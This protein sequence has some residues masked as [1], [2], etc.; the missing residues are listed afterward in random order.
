M[1]A[2]RALWR[3]IKRYLDLTKTKPRNVAAGVALGAFLAFVPEKCGLVAFVLFVVAMTGAS[4]TAAALVGVLLKTV[5]IYV[6][7]D[8]AHAIGMAINESDF[9]RGHAGLWNLPGVA[10]LGLERYHVMGG[11]VLGLI[12]AIPG[13]II[14]YRLQGVVVRLRGKFDE[15]MAL[16]KKAKLED[17]ARAKSEKEGG[18]V[19]AAVAAVAA[20]WQKEQD[21]KNAP[22]PPASFG[23]KAWGLVPKKWLVLALVLVVFDLVG[24]KPAV[25]WALQE[26]F[27]TELA[28]AMGVG[29]DASGQVAQAGKITWDDAGYEVSLLRGHVVM[30]NLHVANPKN[31]KEDLLVA[32]LV[33]MKVDFVALLRRQFVV[34]LMTLDAPQLAVTRAEDGTLSV[35]PNPMADAPRTDPGADWSERA[36]KAMERIKKER[37]ERK[38]KAAEEKKAQKEGKSEE[39][40]NAKKKP[41]TVDEALKRAALG[42]PGANDEL[43][44]PPRWT[45]KKV[46]LNGFAVKVQDPKESVPSFQFKDGLVLE[47]TQDQRANGKPIQCDL[48]GSLV[49]AAQREQGKVEIHFTADP[50]EKTDAE[51]QKPVGWKL[52]VKLVDV[53]LREVDGMIARTIPLRFEKGKATIT[54]DAHGHG[55]DGDLD[56]APKIALKELDARARNP[57]QPICG[58]DATR[59]AQE[60]TNCGAFEMNDVKITGSVLAPKVEVGDTLKNL[61]VQGGINYGKKAA[62]EQLNKGVDKAVEK[63]GGKIPGVDEKKADDLKKGAGGLL[64]KGLGGFGIGGDKK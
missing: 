43:A 53:D 11:A 54:L 14:G 27:P 16:R 18:D 5:S 35:E 31:P 40:A 49:D 60:V 12:A 30:A 15:K 19:A 13:F 8:R 4:G 61:V 9:A 55:L 41:A 24:A 10:L 52:G 6:L 36:Q 46:Q 23:K 37:E 34:E 25:K 62:A 51:D 1:L 47:S 44:A 21:E 2:L 22:R 58:M 50:P 42:L 26:K 63:L 33:D 3:K 7:D 57:G 39:L 59:V 48:V 64:D 32:K 28:K 38:K 20:A 17:A 56:A 45:V 29:R